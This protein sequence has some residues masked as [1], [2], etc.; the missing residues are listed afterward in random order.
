MVD[1]H[2]TIGSANQHKFWVVFN[3]EAD[4]FF[5]LCSLLQEGNQEYAH[6]TESVQNAVVECALLHVRQ[7]VDIL[8]SRGNDADDLNLAVFLP[9]FES[10]RL[11]ELRQAYGSRN[12]IETPCWILNKKLAHPTTHRG[13]SHDYTNLLN[14]LAPL[15]ADI[16]QQVRSLR[17]TGRPV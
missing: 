5:D 10:N 12:L 2:S 13:S 14:Q 16:V 8:L 7:L 15:L 11:A 6:L 1:Q 4:M 17:L 3:Y 9:S